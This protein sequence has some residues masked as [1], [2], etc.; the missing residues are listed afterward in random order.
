[1]LRL[2][3]L[4]DRET[5]TAFWLGA[6]RRARRGLG[7]AIDLILPPQALDEG[8]LDDAERPLTPGLSAR[9]W[10][11]IQFID[12][13]VCDGCGAP[14]AYDL[15]PGALCA[16]CLA[17]PRSTSRARAACLYDEHSRDLILKL[18][19]ADRTDLA[20]LFARWL[21][22][23][24]AELLAEADLICPVPLHPRRLIARRYSQAAEIARP[25]AR[26][27]R[28]AYRPGVLVRA[29]STP[30]QGG[31]SGRGRRE[32]VRG[33]FV[34]PPSVA[35]SLVGKRVLLID[36]VLTTGATAQSCAKA[37][38]KAGAAAVDLAVVA[39]VR[40]SD[41]TPI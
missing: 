3:A 29:R 8:A 22:R 38:L 26:L 18:K 30:T 32:N 37:L 20:P 4:L 39:G 34:V 16:P 11:R 7:H 33:A 21:S 10:E 25:L 36:D 19:H 15:G 24:A 35:A 28:V 5:A 23:A 31:R 14:F 27:S 9:G 41:T 12:G 40:E 6:A 17:R 1:M 2:D 13:P